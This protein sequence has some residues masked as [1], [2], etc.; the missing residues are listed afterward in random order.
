MTLAG[1]SLLQIGATMPDN[2]HLYTDNE[3]ERA[4]Y[5]SASELA[6]E[7]VVRWFAAKD[8]L[9]YMQAEVVRLQRLLNAQGEDTSKTKDLRP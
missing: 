5:R 7:L 2:F 6:K 1:T 3:L 9:D 8:D 4:A